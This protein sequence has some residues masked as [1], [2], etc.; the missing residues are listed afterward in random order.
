[1][2]YPTHINLD[3]VKPVSIDMDVLN[4]LQG[5]IERYHFQS[6]DSETQNL[7]KTF[8]PV[9][10]DFVCAVDNASAYKK[11]IKSLY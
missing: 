6:K 8:L 4:Q 1:M 7:M 11:Q 2:K 3:P 10:V 5:V 9:T